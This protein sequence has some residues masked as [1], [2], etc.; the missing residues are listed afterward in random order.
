MDS[1]AS[2]ASATA[3]SKQQRD[4]IQAAG[5]R[6]RYAIHANTAGRIHEEILP[7][8][9]DLQMTFLKKPT[10]ANRLAHRKATD[11]SPRLRVKHH[12]LVG[13]CIHRI[14]AIVNRI[15]L[16]AVQQAEIS[17]KLQRSIV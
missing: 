5:R 2:S 8:R 11:F 16:R 3:V 9:A 4:E 13:G 1:G 15:E 10:P 14:Q 17:N 7:I 12:N 6:L